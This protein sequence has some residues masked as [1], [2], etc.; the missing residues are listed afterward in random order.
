VH[1]AIQQRLS[2]FYQRREHAGLRTP[3][4]TIPNYVHNCMLLLMFRF[5]GCPVLLHGDEFTLILLTHNQLLSSAPRRVIGSM[6]VSTMSKSAH[7]NGPSLVFSDKP[8]TW[9]ANAENQRN[10]LAYI[11]QERGNDLSVWYNATK[12]W[13][14]KV[15]GSSY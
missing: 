9:W 14:T 10:V 15:G 3:F 5:T 8:A 4:I 1:I 7:D 13:F 11:Q 6:R 12:S 2:W